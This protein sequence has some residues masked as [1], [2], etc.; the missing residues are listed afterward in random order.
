VQG[1]E[2]LS[3]KMEPS[4]FQPRPHIKLQTPD[5]GAETP[6]GAMQELP[7]NLPMKEETELLGN[8]GE[9]RQS[10]Q[11]LKPR[12]AKLLHL[13]SQAL[14]DKIVPVCLSLPSSPASTDTVPDHHSPIS[15]HHRIG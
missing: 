11:A 9:S 5:P 3:E 12:W 13:L 8:P 4:S 7:L 15:K 2:V 1:K 6:Q 14:R 10:G